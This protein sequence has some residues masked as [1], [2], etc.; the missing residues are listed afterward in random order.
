MK[1]L[2][3]L[4]TTS[5]EILISILFVGSAFLY[6]RS[7]NIRPDI[8]QLDRISDSE[9]ER[10]GLYRF[11]RKGIDGI[12]RKSIHRAFHKRLYQSYPVEESD[13][14]RIELFARL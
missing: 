10:D 14:V 11:W 9:R 13:W 5:V 3:K 7:D 6:T 12:K 2:I 8:F 4:L 1:K